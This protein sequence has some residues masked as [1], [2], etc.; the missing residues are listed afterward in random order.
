M[1]GTYGEGLAS[2]INSGI[3]NL[4]QGINTGANAYLGLKRQKVY[5]DYAEM[6][7][8]KQAMAEGALQAQQA[9]VMPVSGRATSTPAAPASLV[10][11]YAGN[12]PMAGPTVMGEAG[13]SVPKWN[14]MGEVGAD[15]LVPRAAA[16]TMPNPGAPAT[17]PGSPAQPGAED[18]SIDDLRNLVF[19]Q[20]KKSRQDALLN[21][22]DTDMLQKAYH[23]QA[24]MNLQKPYLDQ[25]AKALNEVRANPQ[26]PDK[27][28]SVM[29]LTGK[30]DPN[31]AL[32]LAT[33]EYAKL[34]QQYDSFAGNFT[35]LNEHLSSR[36]ITPDMYGDEAKFIEFLNQ[37]KFKPHTPGKTKA[38]GAGVLSRQPPMPRR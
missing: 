12:D 11:K 30:E 26:T 38:P 34:R 24:Q 17:Q 8:R 2:G 13:P 37:M 22:T 10:G 16:Q 36:G 3:Q 32:A 25:W 6:E 31:E 5:E 15:A 28:R 21:A 29:V 4:L 9:D 14:A 35:P 18:L 19:E 20:E 27:W 23:Y 1:P 33:N 7:K